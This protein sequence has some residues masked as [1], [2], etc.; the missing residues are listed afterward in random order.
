MPGPDAAQDVLISW[1]TGVEMPEI[2]RFYGIV[3]K[4]YFA[5]HPPPHFHAI[6][7]E[8]TGLFSIDTLE[9]LEGD[10][11]P[12]AR[13]FVVEWGSRYQSQLRR[14]WQTQVFHKIPGLE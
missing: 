9:M 10:L 4:L 2:S 1:R 13:K 11:P 7:G 12:R 5:D 3:I 6:Y 8:R 14:I